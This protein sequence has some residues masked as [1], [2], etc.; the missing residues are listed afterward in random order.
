MSHIEQRE[1][2]ESVK[3]KLPSF[4][5]NKLVLDI[6]C[7]DINGNNGF[8]FD[9][10]GYL[11]IDIA[12]G[13]N[14]DIVTTGHKLGLPDNTFDVIISTECF[15]HDQFYPKTIKN[16]YRMLKPGGL[17]LFSCA[18]T[19]RPEHGTRATTPEDAP[20][21]QNIDE[22]SDY[23]KNLTELDIKEIFNGKID[24]LFNNYQFSTN[25]KTKDLY[26]FGI[27]S[28]SY[29]ERNDY[30]FIINDNIFNTLNKKQDDILDFIETNIKDLKTDLIKEKNKNKILFNNLKKENDLYDKLVEDSYNKKKSLL[31]DI[32]KCN[33]ELELLKNSNSF[34]VTYPIRLIRR[35]FTGKGFNK[36]LKLIFNNPKLI[37]KFIKN[38]NQ[39]GVKQ[40]VNRLSNIIS[41]TNISP[42]EI[43]RT[44]DINNYNEVFIL[45]TPHCVFIANRIA[46][47]LKKLSIKASI[48]FEKPNDGFS[49]SL[50]FVICPQIYSELPNL[51]IS[52]QLEQSVSSRWFNKNY[53]KIL[54]NSYAI[55]DYS[56]NN[57]PFL[58]ENGLYSQQI[59][60]MPIS[61]DKKLSLKNE[62]E[63]EYEYDVIFYGD[64]YNERRKKYID[65]LS[66]HFKVK[67]ISDLF[68]DKLYKEI[69]KAKIVVNIHYYEDALLE[70]TRL[71]EC[72]S[73]NKLIISEKSSDINQ[74]NELKECIDFVDA[75]DINEMVSRIKYWLENEDKVV[76]K[77]AENINY[78]N[79]CPDMFEFYFM[80]FMLSQDWIS[81]DDF[82]E[83]ANEN[84][85]FK[86][87]FI[88]LGLPEFSKR[89]VDFNKDNKYGI[90]FFPGLRHNIGWIGCG[91]SYKFM[92]RKAKEQGFSKITICE[93]DVE[94]F[95]NFKARY[96]NVQNYLDSIDKDSWDLFAGLIADLNPKVNVLNV[97]NKNNE[98]FIYLDKMTSMVMNTY[99]DNFYDKII[100]WD[101]TNRD[102]AVNT[103]DRHIENMFD[104]KVITTSKYLVG[105][106]EDL[107][108]TLWGFNNTT[109]KEMINISNAK[110]NYKKCLF[111]NK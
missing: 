63:N 99:S 20:L 83:I 25:D 98:E 95:E 7:L 102:S 26:F 33:N 109:Y 79:S 77:T 71:Y 14:V 90:E 35:M 15:E 105:H 55:F 10:C 78:L 62:N 31:L 75:G 65:E 91:L 88:C 17:F 8:L 45:T 16:I 56:E 46:E 60:Y 39:F 70:T 58:N 22:W 23:Y 11:G 53:F 42:V 28:G 61:F 93:D 97:E 108:S 111:L 43:N 72:L 18:T 49:D 29:K 24:N 84:I 44:I 6:G 92:L 74:H 52:F 51:Y 106:K 5:K 100:S 86:T 85:S 96:D 2:C 38:I 110:L 101:Y 13:R 66:K 30:S 80:R 68:G 37:I 34:K 21:L 89:K 9:N 103:I 1:F 107:D 3:V 4:F 40:T 47:N 57:I 82:Y 73:L 87:D 81:F 69:S 67:V 59:H 76:E 32:D 12:E 41:D 50:H 27:K 64:I 48:I 94:F 19:G 36:L 54:E 104:C